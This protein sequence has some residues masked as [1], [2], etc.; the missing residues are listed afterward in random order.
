MSIRFV[1]LGF[2]SHIS[3]FSGSALGEPPANVALECDSRVTPLQSPLA[4]H[5]CA[6]GLR[7]MRETL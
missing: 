4:P 5:C 6:D 3:N 2:L 7:G 1:L